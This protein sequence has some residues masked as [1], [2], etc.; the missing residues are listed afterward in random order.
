MPLTSRRSALFA[1]AALAGCGFAPV[2]GPGGPAEALR[3]TVLVEAPTN[4]ASYVLVR[5]IEER[6]GFPTTPRYRLAVAISVGEEGVGITPAQVTTRYALRG[7]VDWRLLDFATGAQLLAGRAESA[8]G[9]A[10]TATIVATRTARE[11]ARERLMVILADRIVTDL[12][13]R[14]GA[15]P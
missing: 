2:Y 11:D 13:A 15:L 8:T 4:R 6:L 9:Y 12:L 5:R 3:G 1:L 14:S 10:A 7:R